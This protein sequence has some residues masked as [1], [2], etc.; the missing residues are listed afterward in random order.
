MWVVVSLRQKEIKSQC[1]KGVV[2]EVVSL[3]CDG[4]GG[5]RVLHTMNQN[6]SWLE[7]PVDSTPERKSSVSAVRVETHVRLVVLFYVLH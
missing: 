7:L 1:A 5:R 2:R 6:W 3:R 4:G